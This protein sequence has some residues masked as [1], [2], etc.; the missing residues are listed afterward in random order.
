MRNA[1]A[2]GLAPGTVI[3]FRGGLGRNDDP[4]VEHVGTVNGEPFYGP[5]AMVAVHVMAAN[6]NVFVHA[7]NIIGTEQKALT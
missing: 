4:D 7:G 5:P 3:R 2:M 1:E 6:H